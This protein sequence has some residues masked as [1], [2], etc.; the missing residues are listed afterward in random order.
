[1]IP[2]A[3]KAKYELYTLSTDPREQSNLA[4]LLPDRVQSMAR[5]LQR[6]DEANKA[7]RRKLRAT[8]ETHTLELTE[9]EKRRLQ[10]LGYIQ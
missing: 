5:A 10:A 6:L 7:L 3:L 2:R 1:M 9:E 4:T 8:L